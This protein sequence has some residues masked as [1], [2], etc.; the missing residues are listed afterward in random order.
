MPKRRF[1]PVS[2]PALVGNERKYV[3]DCIDSTWISSAGSYVERFEAE[4]A[5]FAGS[6]HA[7]A[8]CNGTV[9]LHLAM[10]AIDI[11]PEDEVIVPAMTFVA[12][13]NAVAYCGAKP[14]FADCDPLTWNIDPNHVESLIS[15]RTKAIIAV[16]LFGNPADMDG[17]Q[18]IA[19]ENGICL[20]EDA[21]EAHGARYKGRSV[22]SLGKLSTFS[23]YGNKI[24]TMGEGG[25][26]TTNDDAL[27]Q[28]INLLKGQGLD[29][30]RRYWHPVMGYNY[31]L[32][33]VAAAI[34][35]GQLERSDWHLKRRREVAIFYQN[36]LQD[37]PRINFQKSSESDEHAYWMTSVVI[38][39]SGERERNNLI[40]QLLL[41][42]VE[43]RPFFV[44]MHQLPMYL[45]ADGCP[46]PVSEYIG[47]AGI[48]LPSSAS[49]DESDQSRVIDSLLELL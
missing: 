16:H 7:I 49:L 29:A 30:H 44:P 13:A 35:L 34:G 10:L 27:S 15:P 14:I 48:C 39:E 42:G 12:T 1:I 46:L 24:L 40:D 19:D 22:G 45:A 23:F 25:V 11:G 28:K 43:T 33:N 17:L 26:V 18:R 5:K 4:F 2:E 32:T 31:R 47:A 21:A 41:Q 36:S 38:K 6:R 9:A 3:L 20:I 8:C 37:H